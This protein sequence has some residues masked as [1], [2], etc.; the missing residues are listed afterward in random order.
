MSKFRDDHSDDDED[1]DGEDDAELDAEVDTNVNA[2]AADGQ[3]TGAGPSTPAVFK[4]SS[5]SSSTPSKTVPTATPFKF[6]STS[7][8]KPKPVYAHHKVRGA[9]QHDR[10]LDGMF[11]PLPKTV[12]ASSSAPGGARSKAVAGPRV[13]G[14]KVAQGEVDVDAIEVDSDSDVE[15][16]SAVAPGARTSQSGTQNQTQ[17]QRTAMAPTAK[18]VDSECYL[19]SILDLRSAIGAS[20]HSGALFFTIDRGSAHSMQS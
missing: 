13:S 6:T 2:H 16:V 5:S 18:I 12:A 7:T 3:N 10:T 8:P 15:E 17:T 11:L 19:Q 4:F 9:T 14:S 1:D 20:R